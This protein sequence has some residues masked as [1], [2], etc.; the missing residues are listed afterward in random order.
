[1]RTQNSLRK[2]YTFEE[3]RKKNKKEKNKKETLKNGEKSNI[4]DNTSKV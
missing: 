4:I 2:T 1:V 3:N